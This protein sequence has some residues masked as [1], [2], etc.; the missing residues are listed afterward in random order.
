MTPSYITHI[1]SEPPTAAQLNAHAYR[2]FELVALIPHGNSFI[3]YF[4]AL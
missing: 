3:A 2:G 4:K 1:F